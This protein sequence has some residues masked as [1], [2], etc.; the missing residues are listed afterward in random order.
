MWSYTITRHLSMSCSNFF[1]C[2]LRL[3]HVLHEGQETT[4][5]TDT[6][7][8]N[9][10]VTII[11]GMLAPRS[12]DPHAL[13]HNQHWEL[14]IIDNIGSGQFR[15]VPFN[16]C[17]HMV[18]F[19]LPN[20]PSCSNVNTKCKRVGY[21]NDGKNVRF[22][23]IQLCSLSMVNQTNIR[24]PLVT[25]IHSTKSLHT[26]TVRGSCNRSSCTPTSTVIL[27]LALSCVHL[28]FVVPLGCMSYS[29]RS[30]PW[31]LR[32]SKVGGW[33]GVGGG[34]RHLV[35]KPKCYGARSSISTL[36]V[37][38][39]GTQSQ[40]RT[41]QETVTLVGLVTLKEP[42]QI[43]NNRVNILATLSG[44]YN[45]S[46]TSKCMIMYNKPSSRGTMTRTLTLQ[47]PKN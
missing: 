20:V 39:I 22:S 24:S 40:K 11:M 35:L 25:R 6:T 37:P 47:V 28:C 31:K 1:Y 27:A 30:E 44:I 23:I 3:L 42:L 45:H 10:A 5:P 15:R 26:Y 13:L 29:A 19:Y 4:F 36:Q 8:Q 32:Q 46:K 43:R 34:K 41:K 7:L 33:G 38:T 9:V 12:Q 2:A 17:V 16:R 21:P 14:P 18:G